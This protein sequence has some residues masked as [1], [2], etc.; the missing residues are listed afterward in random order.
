VRQAWTAHLPSPH[1]IQ[2]NEALSDR[3]GSGPGEALDYA[4]RQ[5][6]EQVLR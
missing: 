2:I 1:A 6:Q 5:E 3:P 4:L